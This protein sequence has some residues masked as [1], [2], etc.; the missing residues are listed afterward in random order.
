M[1]E[2]LAPSLFAAAASLTL[3]VVVVSFLQAAGY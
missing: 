2:T 3:A 1:L